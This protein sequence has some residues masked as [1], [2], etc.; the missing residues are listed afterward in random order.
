MK[1]N[2]HIS[3][4]MVKKFSSFLMTTYFRYF[5]IKGMIAN[6]KYYLNT[7]YF[8]T[9]NKRVVAIATTIRKSF[10]FIPKNGSCN[11][12][13]RRETGFSLELD[14]IIHHTIFRDLNIV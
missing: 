2:I 4:K 12:C 11:L 6:C 3:N 10:P 5:R 13:A 7:S 8:T 1:R 14:K 9:V